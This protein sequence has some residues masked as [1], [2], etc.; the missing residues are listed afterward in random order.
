MRGTYCFVASFPASCRK[1]IM[2]FLNMK[3][4]EVACGEVL[5]TLGAAIDMCLSVVDFIVFMGGKRESLS[6]GRER[7]THDLRNG[8]GVSCDLHSFQRWR[9]CVFSS[10]WG[11]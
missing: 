4:Q 7:T 6:M 1:R 11:P 10:N 2:V 8:N 3:F 5:A 9:C